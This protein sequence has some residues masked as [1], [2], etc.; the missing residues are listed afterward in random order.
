MS[1]FDFI[2]SDKFPDTSDHQ[3]FVSQSVTVHVFTLTKK[4]GLTFKCIGKFIVYLQFFLNQ[5][6]KLSTSQYTFTNK[7]N[8]QSGGGG[9]REEGGHEQVTRAFMT[10]A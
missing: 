6:F 10:L 9:E 5:L 2:E 4:E 7:L 8:T 1:S 3:S